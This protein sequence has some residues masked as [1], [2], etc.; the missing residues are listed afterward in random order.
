MQETM[1]NEKTVKSKQALTIIYAYMCN[2]TFIHYVIYKIHIHTHMHSHTHT[3]IP[4][5]DKLEEMEILDNNHRKVESRKIG[6]SVL[7]F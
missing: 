4:M 2:T 6:V 1:V 3:Q 7:K 5:G